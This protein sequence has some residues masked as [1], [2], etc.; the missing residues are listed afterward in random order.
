M[1]V[2]YLFRGTAAEGKGA[3]YGRA[4][5]DAFLKAVYKSP[6]IALHTKV[7]VGDLLL[8]RLARVVE[9]TDTGHIE[10]FDRDLFFKAVD[11]WL[12]PPNA[13]WLSAGQAFMDACLQ[14]DIYVVLVESVERDAARV[15]S[16]RPP[17]TT[18]VQWK[19]TTSLV[20]TGLY[21]R[22]VWFRNTA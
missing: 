6:A 3:S 9:D 20:S 2:A 1:K 12:S 4:I 14:H 21:I 5:E 17:R 15:L 18:W 8:E 22:I 19:S 11:A 7:F 10:H 13:I 16:E